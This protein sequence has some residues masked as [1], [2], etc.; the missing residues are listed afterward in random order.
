VVE[1]LV[2]G[3]V[4]IN[5]GQ[6]CQAALCRGKR[7]TFH[8]NIKAARSLRRPMLWSIPPQLLALRDWCWFCAPGRDR[9]RRWC[10]VSMVASLVWDGPPF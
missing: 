9:A 8:L 1:A 2:F 6:R 7:P 4:P 3:E 10:I 5:I